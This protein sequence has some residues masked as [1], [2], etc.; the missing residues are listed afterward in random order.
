M[1][2]WNNRHDMIVVER[3]ILHEEEVKYAV[4]VLQSLDYK[5]GEQYMP[6][7]LLMT[8]IVQ[9]FTRGCTVETCVREIREEN[10]ELM[11]YA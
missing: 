11:E 4:R 8:R 5:A 10:K 7:T 1:F 3:F 2:R 6:D 9:G